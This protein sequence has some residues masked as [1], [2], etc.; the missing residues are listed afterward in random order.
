MIAGALG[1]AFT[2][3]PMVSG[4]AAEIKV[5]SAVGLRAVL[6]ELKPRFERE[7]QHKL[8]FTFSTSISQKRQIDAGESF[9]VV[10]L[11]PSLIEELIR[12]NK[13]APGTKADVAKS[14]IGV[15]VRAGAPKPDIGTTEAFKRALLNAKSIVHTQEGQSGIY[16]ASLIERLGLAAETKPKTVVETRAGHI[17]A[18]VVEGKAELGLTVMSGIVPVPGAEL[19]GPLPAELQNYIVFTAGVSPDAADPEAAKAFIRFLKAPAAL[20]VLKTMGMEP[21]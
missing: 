16:I 19:V 20:P 4:N 14:G 2:F 6:E 3:S 5:I 12:Q 11:S 18:A 1:F 9:D 8:A 7:T 10:V 15:V 13:V 17:A 21:G